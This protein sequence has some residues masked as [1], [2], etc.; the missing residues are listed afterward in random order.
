MF[1]NIQKNYKKLQKEQ[2][3]R[4]IHTNEKWWVRSIEERE[5]PGLGELLSAG[6]GGGDS[7]A[8]A[9]RPQSIKSKL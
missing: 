8:I 4:W 5:R 9:N 1:S 7:L 6:L 3:I 2:R